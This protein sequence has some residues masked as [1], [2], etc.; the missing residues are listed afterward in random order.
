MNYTE[1]IEILGSNMDDSMDE[2]TKNYRAK[3]KVSHPDQGGNSDWFIAVRGAYKII[4]AG[5]KFN[6][7]TKN[8]ETGE[9]K[10]EEK[11]L[12]QELQ[13]K[14][15]EVI[16][17]IDNELMQISILGTWIWLSGETKSSK[18]DIKKLGF[19]FSKN[20]TAWYWHHGEYKRRSKKRFSLSDIEIM[21]GKVDVEKKR[22]TFL[23]A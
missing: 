4:L 23:T 18:E 21:H 15:T 6:Q 9:W 22:K 14:L 8:G 11:N 10:E 16:D 20:K 13:D 7:K 12:P 19:R 1:A 17:G 3:L 2:I 5:F